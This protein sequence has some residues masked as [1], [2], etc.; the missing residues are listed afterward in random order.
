MSLF[1]CYGWEVLDVGNNAI[2]DTFP[3]CLVSLGELRVLIL[4]WNKFP[5]YKCLANYLCFPML[6]IFYLSPNNFS[7]LLLSKVYESWRMMKPDDKH[8]KYLQIVQWNR[9][10]PSDWLSFKTIVMNEVLRV[11]N[12]GR[13]SLKLFLLKS[14]NNS[15]TMQGRTGLLNLLC[16]EFRRVKLLKLNRKGRQLWRKLNLS[17][18]YSRLWKWSCSR[19]LVSELC[20]RFR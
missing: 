12:G 11:H 4:K 19:W 5:D 6:W 3:A 2:N 7:C 18:R 20:E 9:V 10:V 14:S 13:L 17:S 16:D 1:N 15:S 8:E